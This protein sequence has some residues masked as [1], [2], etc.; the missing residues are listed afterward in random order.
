MANSIAILALSEDYVQLAL[1]LFCFKLQWR[2]SFVH[3]DNCRIIITIE[4][5]RLRVLFSS[6]YY[7]NFWFGGYFINLF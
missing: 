6:D 3:L 7:F 2:T 1:M 5:D 4:Q